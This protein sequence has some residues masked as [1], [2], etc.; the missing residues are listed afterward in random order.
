MTASSRMNSYTDI[1]RINET[2]GYSA[3]QEG[4]LLVNEK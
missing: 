2:G 3:V 4:D 1:N